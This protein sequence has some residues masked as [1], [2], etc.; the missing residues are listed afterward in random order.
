MLVV[1]SLFV[2]ANWTFTRFVNFFYPC[3]SICGDISDVEMH[4]VLM[5]CADTN[6]ICKTD[7]K[8][9]RNSVELCDY[10]YST[11]C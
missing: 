10:S 6:F 8:I 4:S 2:D 5:A 7:N 9:V 11:R 3:L 1:K